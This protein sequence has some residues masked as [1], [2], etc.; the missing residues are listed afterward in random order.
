MPSALLDEQAVEAVFSGESLD[1][2]LHDAAASQGRQADLPADASVSALP[3]Y[4]SLHFRTSSH[5]I[6]LRIIL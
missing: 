1:M 3:G 4:I 6:H 5:E 2:R